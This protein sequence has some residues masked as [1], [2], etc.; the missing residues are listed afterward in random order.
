MTKDKILEFLEKNPNSSSTTI[1]S[2]LG[3]TTVGV[4]Y[5][6]KRL[7]TNEK[8]EVQWKSKA[9]RYSIKENFS[10][11]FDTKNLLGRIETDIRET[12]EGYD[13]KN[14]VS[15]L[16]GILLILLPDGVW[17]EG[18]DAFYEIIKKENQWKAPW[19][20]LFQ[21]R[22]ASFIFAYL[23]EEKKRRKNGFFD[24]TESIE[25]NTQKYDEVC[26]VDHVYFYQINKL[27]HWWK[28]RTGTE[29][30]HG[31]LLQDRKLLTAAVK[32]AIPI[33][34]QYFI[35]NNVDG[36]VLTPPTLQRKAQFRDIFMQNFDSTS[37]EIRAEKIKNKQ[38]RPQ[39]ELS[40]KD[41]FINANASI[42]VDLPKNTTVLKHIVI[43]DDNFTTGAT[44]NTIA[45]KIRNGGYTG[46]IDV[47][48]IAWNFTYIPW[49]TDIE[50][51]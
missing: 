41:R 15:L 23:D 35:K 12:Y 34:Q 39:K 27:W 20:E 11:P 36:I 31:K 1:A 42:E 10:I 22:L 32:E 24:W 16:K 29:I 14:I 46:I 38:F 48:T 7:I 9:T 33:I 40:G 37:F 2:Y 3:I 5:H 13:G 45:S 43:I 25:V 26:H 49:V 51:I 50:E 6:M 4:F 44:V 28:L 18:I 17:R 8:V 47:I 30:Y 19:E 21:K